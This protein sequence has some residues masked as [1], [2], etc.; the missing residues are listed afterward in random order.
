MRSAVWALPVA[1]ITALGRVLVSMSGSPLMVSS[2]TLAAGTFPSW[3]P[4]RAGFDRSP[5]MFAGAGSA[6]SVMV[7]TGSASVLHCP[8]TTAALSR[9]SCLLKKREML[10]RQR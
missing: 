9:A 8:R 10:S 3:W 6:A 7:T 2:W 4:C 5:S 1:W